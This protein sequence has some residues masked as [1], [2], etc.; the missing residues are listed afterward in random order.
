MVQIHVFPLHCPPLEFCR[1]ILRHYCASRYCPDWLLE[2]EPWA[3]CVCV[4]L[5][6]LVQHRRFSTNMRP[7]HNMLKRL[8][9][10]AVRG[11]PRE[12]IFISRPDPLNALLMIFLRRKNRKKSSPPSCAEFWVK[13]S[14]GFV[15]GKAG[16]NCL[17]MIIDYVW[18][19]ISVAKWSISLS[20][21]NFP[22]EP[23]NRTFTNF[24]IPI[25]ESNKF[26]LYCYLS[27]RP[28]HWI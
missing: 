23:K 14:C 8:I 24:K 20:W 1:S 7:T 11:K 4:T 22:G 18:D 10:T 5:V 12:I 6:S 2:L 13:L 15:L 9:A 19:K 16:G 28:R 25:P 21:K 26:F 17:G 27:L 3:C